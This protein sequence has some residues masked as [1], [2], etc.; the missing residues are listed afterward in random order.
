[1]EGDFKDMSAA[2]EVIRSDVELRF[3]SPKPLPPVPVS[4]SLPASV[5]AVTALRKMEIALHQ[6]G[7]T[8]P[9][10][11]MTSHYFAEGLYARQWA[12][13]AG[14]LAISKIH[15]KQNFL[16]LLSGE[17]LISTGEQTTHLVAPFITR[18]MPGVKRAVYA[19]TDIALITFHPNPD[20]EQDMKKLEER[21]IIPE[22]PWNSSEEDGQ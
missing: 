2:P 7:N 21:Y 9:I 6:L 3:F 19:I 22:R 14:V 20:N 4:E 5:E 1:M 15:A 12:Q 16:L 13:P 11:E 18:T 10:E 8:M 17:C